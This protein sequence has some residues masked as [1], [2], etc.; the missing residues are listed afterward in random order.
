MTDVLTS[1]RA[2][3]LR[4]SGHKLTGARLAVLTALEQSDGHLTSSE[5]I[6]RVTALDPTVGRASV[7]RALD[8]FTRLSLVRPTYLSGSLTPAYVLLPGGHHHHFVCLQ[9]GRVIEV[10]HCSLRGAARE[11]EKQL[12]VQVSGHLVEFFGLCAACAALPPAER[13]A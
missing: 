5:L 2:Q 1:P 13:E 10:E 3:R 6:E 12:G 11:L 4:D 7:F 9:C 8:L